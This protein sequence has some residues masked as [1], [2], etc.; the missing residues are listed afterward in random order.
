MFDESVFSRLNEKLES[1]RAKIQLDNDEIL[2]RVDTKIQEEDTVDH[3]NSKRDA[4]LKKI[5]HKLQ[6]SMKKLDETLR[7]D[8]KLES[9][10]FSTVLDDKFY[11]LPNKTEDSSAIKHHLAHERIRRNEFELFKKLNYSELYK[12]AELINL[13][14]H[15]A[16]IINLFSLSFNT[17]F[18]YDHKSR[19]LKL[20]D[21]KFNTI[22]SIGVRSNYHCIQYEIARERIICNFSNPDKS[23][24]YASS[25]DFHLNLIKSRLISS[26]EITMIHVGQN[27]V[28]Y[29]CPMTNKYVVLDLDLNDRDSISFDLVGF[30]FSFADDKILKY[31]LDKELTISCRRNLNMVRSISLC[32][33]CVVNADVQ[34]Q[35]TAFRVCNIFFDRKSNIFVMSRSRV[36]NGL[37]SIEYYDLNGT[38]ISKRVLRDVNEYSLFKV[39]YD[40]IYYFGEASLISIY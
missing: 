10:I 28:Y 16:H 39:F 29:T 7:T 12:S 19:E 22:R 21:K 6:T 30:V 40:C 3:L 37:Y 15:Y 23:Q 24:T 14:S 17:N 2:R 31:Y 32:G 13:P 34:K 9:S 5:E 26:K 20:L 4:F 11:F 35:A 25:F 18:I 33:D 27:N 8:R 1:L 38:L 36:D